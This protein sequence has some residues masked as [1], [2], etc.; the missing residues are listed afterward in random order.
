MSSLSGEMS[1]SRF[2]GE[3]SRVSY[4]HM[5]TVSGDSQSQGERVGGVR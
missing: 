2:D 5:Q 1:F 3:G 4:F